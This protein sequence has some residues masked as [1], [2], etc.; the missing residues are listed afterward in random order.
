MYSCASRLDTFAQWRLYKNEIKKVF[1]LLKIRCIAGVDRCILTHLLYFT[2][3]ISKKNRRI[4]EV[5]YI[6]QF[7]DHWPEDPFSQIYFVTKK[8]IKN[9]KK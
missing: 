7:C 6:L 9:T 8:Y 5:F 4:Q 1:R 3:S 2:G